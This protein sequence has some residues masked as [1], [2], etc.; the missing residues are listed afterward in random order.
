MSEKL[1]LAIRL[2]AE[3]KADV[4][5]FVDLKQ[6]SQDTRRALKQMQEALRGLDARIKAT[7]GK[8][9]R[10]PGSSS[11]LRRPATRR[12]VSGNRQPEHHKNPGQCAGRTAGAAK[13]WRDW[14]KSV[15]PDRADKL[16][17]LR[18]L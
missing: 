5:A 9:T 1:K 18:K 12:A 14:V 8:D 15:N 10:T 2:S 16:D 6:K 3:T 4:K 11:S 7:G 13:G 17:A